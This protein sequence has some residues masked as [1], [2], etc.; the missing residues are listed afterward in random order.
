VSNFKKYLKKIFNTGLLIQI[1]NVAIKLSYF[2]VV[3]RIISFDTS[4]KNMASF[5]ICSKI[6][7][8][9]TIIYF[10]LGTVGY[11]LL[12]ASEKQY[13]HPRIIER[14]FL[15]TNLSHVFQIFFLSFFYWKCSLFTN[16]LFIIDNI[17][18]FIPY[19]YLLLI[20]QGIGHV[21]FGILQ[22]YQKYHSQAAVSVVCLIITGVLCKY[23]SNM[24]SL[25]WLSIV[26]T[27][28]RSG[29][30]HYLKPKIDNPKIHYEDIN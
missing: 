9:G 7:D 3:R 25:L 24:I 30:L 2:L 12:P 13:Q 15:W 10:G 11:T 22:G 1:R 8:L 27:G 23:C 6:L 14:L 16:D 29:L 26:I 19:I 18:T 28:I 4:G 17:R 5:V 21:N 20:G